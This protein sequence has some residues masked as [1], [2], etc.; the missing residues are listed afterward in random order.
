[1]G[2]LGQFWA[3]LGNFG[4]V[5]TIKG[6]KGQ[7]KLEKEQMQLEKEQMQ[8]EKEEKINWLVRRRRRR[9]K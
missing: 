6:K 8:L 9:R 5:R 4:Q 7:G 2:K 1:M 3:S